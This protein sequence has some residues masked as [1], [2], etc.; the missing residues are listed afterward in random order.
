MYYYCI[1][2]QCDVLLLSWHTVQ[3]VCHCLATVRTLVQSVRT[4]QYICAGLFVS[5]VSDP[6][7]C[8]LSNGAFSIQIG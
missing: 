1:L 2:Y 3:T 8:Q 7:P 5:W 6:S 4:F